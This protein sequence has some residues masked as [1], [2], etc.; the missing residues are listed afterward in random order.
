MSRSSLLSPPGTMQTPS[1][2]TLPPSV[3]CASLLVKP[4]AFLG[5]VTLR[6]TSAKNRCGFRADRLRPP[7]CPTLYP[8][9]AP[10]SRCRALRSAPM[11][12]NYLGKP[13]E[14]YACYFR[15]VVAAAL[16]SFLRSAQA[17][18]FLVLPTH[19]GL[20]NAR[21]LACGTIIDRPFGQREDCSLRARRH[22]LRLRHDVRLRSP[23]P[24]SL[25]RRA[26]GGRETVR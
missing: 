25:R 14:I 23:Y 26:S 12:A 17:A 6:F 2:R 1:L 9:T 20:M 15:L 4:E 16:L 8:D 13:P 7:S 10:T 24:N 11:V 3:V 18:A 19:R 21:W 22:T 5:E